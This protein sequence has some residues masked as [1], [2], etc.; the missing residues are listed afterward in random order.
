M[1]A[2]HV[3]RPVAPPHSGESIFVSFPH[4]EC[5]DSAK[6]KLPSFGSSVQG[7]VLTFLDPISAVYSVDRLEE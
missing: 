2:P 1:F 5:N 7:L 3:V 6:S 4:S